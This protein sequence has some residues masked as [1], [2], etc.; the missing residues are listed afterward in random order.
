MKLDYIDEAFKKLD[1]L[2]EEAFT[3]SSH[4][5]GELDNFLSQD[6]TSELVKVIDPDATTPEE[7]SPSYVG[8]IITNC[9][10]CHSN[11]FT[12]KNDIMIN[13]DGIVNIEKQ[14]PYC[15]EL[16]GFIILGEIV[17]FDPNAAEENVEEP[18]VE[19]DG[20]P[21]EETS[22]D[23]G[24]ALEESL[25][26]WKPHTLRL[27]KLIGS[28][29]VNGIEEEGLIESNNKSN[30]NL[31]WHI[32]STDK[33]DDGVIFYRARK[34]GY[35]FEIMH[36][37]ESNEIS[38]D[39]AIS[40]TDS[41]KYN[42]IGFSSVEE[43]KEYC[44]KIFRELALSDEESLTEAMNNVNV[45][46]DDTIVTV[47]SDEN[48]KVTVSTEPKEAPA[49]EAPVEASE[50][51][52]MIAPL[53]DDTIADIE[54]VATQEEENTEEPVADTEAEEPSDEAALSNEETPDEEV[55]VDLD[56]VDEEGLDEL[57][58]SYFKRVYENVDS[59]KTSAIYMPGNKLI[60][61][62]LLTFTSGT[63]KKTGFV[64][65]A[66]G[67]DDNGK[68]L[69]EGYNPQLSRGKKAFSLLGTVS[70]N[71][72][73]PESLKY[74]YIARGTDTTDKVSGKI[75]RA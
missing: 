71:K 54:A 43:A 6:D 13:E 48:G 44:E 64:F 19:V 35:G 30:N 24:E 40:H 75:T 33:D 47:N 9:N 51:G 5:M 3:F 22:E 74:N 10:V 8:K 37:L 56:E 18:V 12:D 53:S 70:A 1:L 72:F 17:P 32:D 50:E 20:E 67:A 63:S 2:N 16:E 58:E 26:K 68:V 60:V 62:G 59:Y 73:L 25:G 29:M 45:E 57:G 28:D 14:C 46:T 66:I 31:K 4:N 7:L 34:Y 15:G 23:N 42:E 69:F 52:D 39:V 65:E 21:V 55:E 36:E 61:E 38:V 41:E 27:L 49:D 11:V